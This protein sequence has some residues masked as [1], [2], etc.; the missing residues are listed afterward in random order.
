MK[1]ALYAR[2]SSDNQREESIDA[3][4]RAMKEYSERNDIQIIKIYTDEAKSA[5]TDNRPQFRQ[6]IKD[7][8]LGLFDI[9]LVHKLDRFSRNRY[10]S[11]FYK[12]QLK[13]NGVKVMSVLELL[14]DSPE[15]IILES[16]LEG[17]AEYYSANLA[18]EVMKGMKETA[19][20]CKHNG[21]IP[22]LGYDIA[23]DKTLIINENEKHAVILIYTLYSNG[24][25]YNEIVDELNKK[26]FK[27]KLG[28]SFGKNSISEIL[29]NEKYI[30]TYTFN[31]T[32]R[33]FAGKNVKKIKGEE[34]IIRVE[35]GT[36]QIID[37]SLWNKVQLKLNKNKRAKGSNSAKE[38]YLL[39]G[40][41]VCGS[42]DGAMVGN[43]KRAG[44]NK[45]M[46]VSYECSTRKRTKQCNAK[47]INRDF[48]EE[49]VVNDL[50]EK[51]LSPNTLEY[52]STKIY[53][54]AIKQQEIIK[55]DVKIIEKKLIEIQKQIDN[56]INAITKGMFHE[57][58]KEKM[59]ELENEKNNLKIDLY[60]TKVQFEKY[61]PKIDH[62]K[63][64][65]SNDSNIK[66][67]E[68]HEQKEIIN[69]YIKKVLL[70]EDKIEIHYIVDFDDGGGGSRTHV[71]KYFHKTF[72]E[73][74]R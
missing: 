12:R 23:D 39:S 2:F 42:C 48:I 72:S 8:T 46:Y 61:S 33:Q 6:L 17:M 36:P 13:L 43:R 58:M 67:K 37:K 45:D 14:N 21:G 71:R 18:R 20:Q 32:N 15:S 64:Y 30:G 69:R 57:S 16:V 31:K 25:G 49:F 66:T 40:L 62:I 24:F 3:Q 27:T 5:T 29:R 68:F 74:R 19:L 60:E 56:I 35:G 54:S 47:S 38:N 70:N 26:G 59:D 11:A 51:I 50:I 1:A 28:N 4:V 73:C 22:P 34:E 44:R 52:I 55:S 7:S 9:V 41:L 63:K 53:N 65:L 10:D